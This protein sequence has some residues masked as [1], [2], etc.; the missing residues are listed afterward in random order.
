MGDTSGDTGIEKLC[1][2]MQRMISQLMEQ[3]Q[4]K[5]SSTSE[6]LKTLEPNPVRLN[7]PGDF[8]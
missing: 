4:R 2:S 8:F 5:T 7:G 6:I 3:A 1:E